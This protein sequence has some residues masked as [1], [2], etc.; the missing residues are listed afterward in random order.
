MPMAGRM[1][2]FGR[3]S[4]GTQLAL[5]G[6]GPTAH[7]GRLPASHPPR[8]SSRAPKRHVQTQVQPQCSEPRVSMPQSSMTRRP[9]R[10]PFGGDESATSA[11]GERPF[12]S[13]SIRRLIPGR[14]S[15]ASLPV[16][17]FPMAFRPMPEAFLSC[18]RPLPDGWASVSA[19]ACLSLLL[20]VNQFIAS[21]EAG[22]PSPLPDAHTIRSTKGVPV[23]N[24]LAPQR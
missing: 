16:A 4:D 2:R 20:A 19:T 17:A 22:I 6:S 8:G 13:T 12:G 1:L 14:A 5:G 24:K 3:G 18:S 7:F 10:S 9:R 21:G 15:P 23:K 11:T